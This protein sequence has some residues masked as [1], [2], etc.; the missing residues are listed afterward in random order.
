[1][2]DEEKLD[3]C[4]FALILQCAEVDATNM[5]IIQRGVSH[6]INNKPL[7]NWRITVERIKPPKNEYND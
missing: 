4:C 7:G 2:N 1:M 6:A 5:E 3:A